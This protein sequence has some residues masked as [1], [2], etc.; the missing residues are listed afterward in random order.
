VPRGTDINWEKKSDVS[1]EIP[2]SPQ[3]I[4]LENQL[5]NTNRGPEMENALIIMI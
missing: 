2:A 3:V 1:C 5:F 4:L